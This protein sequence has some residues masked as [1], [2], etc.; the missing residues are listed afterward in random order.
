MNILAR[1]KLDLGQFEGSDEIAPK[2]VRFFSLRRL[3]VK[4]SPKVYQNFTKTLPNF[5]EFSFFTSD[6]ADRQ[7]PGRN[8]GAHG[9]ARPTRQMTKDDQT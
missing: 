2:S 1:P 9:T 3:L 8:N 4:I 7:Q 6:V 5:T